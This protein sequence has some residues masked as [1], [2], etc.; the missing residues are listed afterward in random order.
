MNRESRNNRILFEEMPPLKALSTM[1]IPMVISQLIILIYNMADT[2]F[3]GKTNNPYMVAG[4]SLILPVFNVSIAF[5]NIAGTGGGTLIARLLGKERTEDARRVAAFSFWFSILAGLVF[6]LATLFLMHPLLTALGASTETFSYARQYVTCVIVIGAVPT[7]LSMTLGNLLRNTGNAAQAG[8]GVSMGGML[9]MLLDPLFMFVLLPRGKEILGA[10]M[11]TALSNVVVCIYFLYTV[12]HLRNPVLNFTPK[13]AL[14]EREEIASFFAVGVPA[15][16]GPFLFDLDYVVI[17]RLMSS[18][19]DIALAAMGIVLKAER[20][21]LNIGIGLCLG[22]V[23]LAAYNYSSGNLKRMEEF[24]KLTRRIGTLVCIVSIAL[25]EFFAPM[26]M[27]LMI[28]EE[29]TIA[30]GSRFLRIRALATIVMF[31]SFSYVHFFQAVGQG[32][33]AFFLAVMRWGMVNIPMLFLLN[34][35]FGMYGIVWSQLVSDIIV[36]S[37]SWITYRHFRKRQII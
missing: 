1:A 11:A 12:H 26:L 8:F 36:A 35:L 4:A 32:K 15:A 23:P 34:A 2:F 27:R 29:Q 17:D 33:Y 24:L 9:N 7:I 18:Y 30:L 20:L 28:G 6:S 13:D 14:P 10:G 25:Y 5:A 37:V 16:I 21:P 22:M 19:S 31:L 3:L